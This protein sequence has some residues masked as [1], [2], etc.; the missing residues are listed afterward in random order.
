MTVQERG[1]EESG[2]KRSLGVTCHK[3]I[4]V[5]GLVIRLAAHQ[6][7]QAVHNP[8]RIFHM[9]A[10]RWLRRIQCYS[11]ELGSH[12]DRGSMNSSYCLILACRFRRFGY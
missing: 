7:A 3:V 9:P 4:L 2:G 8:P 6:A 11:T 10:F 12:R 1:K 5:H